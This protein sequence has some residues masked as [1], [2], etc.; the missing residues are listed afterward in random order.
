M[1]MHAS[2]LALA[3]PHESR[4]SSR[5]SSEALAQQTHHGL[6]I[7]RV[8]RAH[9]EFSRATAHTRVHQSQA[10]RRVHRGYDDF[11]ADN[12]DDARIGPRL[13]QGF[14]GVGRR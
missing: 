12:T 8:L 1:R 4:P 11:V 13:D 10:L 14:E 7:R 2:A 9:E 6:G 3:G 5:S